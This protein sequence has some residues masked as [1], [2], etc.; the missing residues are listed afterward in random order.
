MNFQYDSVTTGYPVGRKTG[1]DFYLKPVGHKNKFKTNDL[2]VK[3]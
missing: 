3:R 2:K 1:L